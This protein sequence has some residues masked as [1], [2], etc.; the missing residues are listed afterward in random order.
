MIKTLYSC[1]KLVYMWQEL[2]YSS[3]LILYVFIII[4]CMEAN[5]N[6]ILDY[7]IKIYVN[8]L[9]MSFLTNYVQA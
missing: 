2:E 1:F 6:I 4:N 8:I 3:K 7:Y 5:M 9:I